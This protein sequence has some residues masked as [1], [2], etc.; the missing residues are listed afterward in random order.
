M[1]FRWANDSR[2]D[3]KHLL[4][5]FLLLCVLHAW[6]EALAQPV[7]S[8]LWHPSDHTHVWYAKGSLQI[9]SGS[10]PTDPS[11]SLPLSMPRV[12]A[13]AFA[14]EGDWLMA[15]GGQ[16]GEYGAIQQLRWPSGE[17]LNRWEFGQDWFN[18]LTLRADGSLLA[19]GGADG[20]LSLLGLDQ[21]DVGDQPAKAWRAHSD[22]ITDL[23][24]DPTGQWLLSAGADRVIKL[25]Q[26]SDWG[27]HRS[28]DAH[29][30]M[31]H[32]LDL[33]PYSQ[34]DA[35]AED[36]WQ[37]ASASS[38]QTIRIWQPMLGRMVRIVRPGPLPQLVVAYHRSGRWLAS[39]GQESMIYLLDAD[40]DRILDQIPTQQ[41][42]IYSLSFS[43]DGTV[44][45]AGDWLGEVQSYPVPESLTRMP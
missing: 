39:A 9:G 34:G 19:L 30:D 38:D 15:A 35:V 28:L 37:V 23:Q 26:C 22:A 25:W 45:M 42:W 41:D 16:P 27:L 13:L 10:R 11:I 43:P 1:G 5:A 29:T 8:V 4:P 44:L 3:L 21:P 17:T 18:A 40:S 12:R 7:S 6:R 14:P 31:I 32:S 33:R 36:A 20:R 2:I 24:F